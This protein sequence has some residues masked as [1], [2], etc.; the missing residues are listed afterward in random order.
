M[1]EKNSKIV[2]TIEP[3]IP[4]AGSSLVYV[5]T[6]LLCCLIISKFHSVVKWLPYKDASMSVMLIA[7]I[8]GLFHISTLC[9]VKGAIKLLSKQFEF[10]RGINMSIDV[11]MIVFCVFMWWLTLR[12]MNGVAMT[13]YPVWDSVPREMGIL[14][15]G[16]DEEDDEKEANHSK[17]FVVLAFTMF[18]V[19]IACYFTTKILVQDLWDLL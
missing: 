10:M 12:I 7:I 14:D 11:M 18:F 13:Y 19:N 17:S 2:W 9:I 5:S 15:E 6:C 1:D 8:I 16:D 3:E 4:S